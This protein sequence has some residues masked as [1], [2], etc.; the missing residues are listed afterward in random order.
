MDSILLQQG[1]N[2]ETGARQEIFER[3]AGQA[4]RMAELDMQK[5]SVLRPTCDGFDHEEIDDFQAVAG[6][7]VH[8]GILTLWTRSSNSVRQ[9]VAHLV[10]RHFQHAVSF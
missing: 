6:M 1:T 7:A 3:N 8:G 2:M 9:A 5:A 4:C 10:A